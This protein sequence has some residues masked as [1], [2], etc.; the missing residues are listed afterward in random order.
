MHRLTRL[1]R[2]QYYRYMQRVRDAVPAVEGV[3]CGDV[4]SSIEEA[5]AHC[6]AAI[7]GAVFVARLRV[8]VLRA[9]A[10]SR[11]RSTDSSVRP[12]C[13]V[14]RSARAE[15]ALQ[16]S[17][18]APTWRP[19]WPRTCTRSA[20]RQ[21]PR[22]RRARCYVPKPAAEQQLA[23]GPVA[24]APRFVLLF[25]GTQFGWATQL[26]HLFPPGETVLR[27]PSFHV[28]GETDPFKPTVRVPC[29]AA[30]LE[31]LTQR[32]AERGAG[33]ALRRDR[34]E[35]GRSAAPHH[36]SPCWSQAAPAG[37]GR[38]CGGGR[39]ADVP[40]GAAATK[41]ISIAR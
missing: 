4:Y 33:G 29:R 25:C 19:W 23:A 28:F 41:V 9:G 1:R 36:H 24:G 7:H 11:G 37:A 14:A 31:E 30:A 15:A 17:R 39:R 2:R 10:Q 8:L 26:P 13:A 12:R 22:V 20:T 40:A 27:V 21:T 6:V 34:C 5:I 35:H 38:S 16:A 3:T 18:R 32:P